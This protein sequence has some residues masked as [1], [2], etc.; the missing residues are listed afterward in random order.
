MHF[1]IWETIS[2]GN[3]S[4]RGIRLFL[5]NDIIY[6]AAAVNWLISDWG[7]LR[8]FFMENMMDVSAGVIFIMFIFL[9][10][11]G[12]RGSRSSRL[13]L[14]KAFAHKN[15][16][17]FHPISDDDFAGSFPEEMRE[18]ALGVRE[19]LEGLYGVD[20]ESIPADFRQYFRLLDYYDS[21]AMVELILRLE[22]KFGIRTKDE[23]FEGIKTIGDLI[24]YI[25]NLRVG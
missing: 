13:K 10:V 19:E 1:A 5:L 16:M 2:A 23:D 8:G 4:Y 24:H 17:N 9:A 3:L 7:N 11:M 20:K 25:Y 21:L 12:W 18:T 15:E 6:G 14:D 22:R